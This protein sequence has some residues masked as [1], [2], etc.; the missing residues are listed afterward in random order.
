MRKKHQED[1]NQAH[2]AQQRDL[3]AREIETVTAQLEIGVENLMPD[4]QEPIG[5]K[6]LRQQR[7]A[8]R[9]AVESVAV[10]H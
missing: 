7:I 10:V 8:G 2:A 4:S 9:D 6:Q 1:A 5:G 3:L